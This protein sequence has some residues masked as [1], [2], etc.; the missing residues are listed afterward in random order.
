MRNTKDFELF[1]DLRLSGVGM[2]GVVHATNPVDSIQRFIGRIEMGVIPQVIDTVIF[3]KNGGVEKVLSLA[4]TVKVP[5]GMTEADLAR[6]VVV[7]NDFETGKLEHEIYTYGEQTIVVPVKDQKLTGVMK[8][9][10]EKVRALLLEFTP[11]PEIEVVSD[12]KVIVRVPDKD[13]PKVIGKQGSTISRI[14][15]QLGMSIEVIS[16]GKLPEE[17]KEIAQKAE[18]EFEMDAKSGNY[19]TMNLGSHC[20]YKDVDV[21]LGDEFLLTAK[22]GKTGLIQI[23][24]SNDVGQKILHAI[25]EGK[26]VK[27]LM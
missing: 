4:M 12:H 6:P 22:A 7:I 5:A 2:V 18:L 14:E 26:K 15:S 24:K 13:V 16:L 23:K 19:V 27:V 21:Y 10:D 9:V 17:K 20:K 1:S 11:N 3:I 25:T 8:I